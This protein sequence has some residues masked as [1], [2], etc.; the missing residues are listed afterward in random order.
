MATTIAGNCHYNLLAFYIATPNTHFC[1]VHKLYTPKYTKL[2][3]HP[4]TSF[5]IWVNLKCH[6]IHINM[7]TTD[8]EYN[9]HSNEYYCQ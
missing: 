7:Y 8:N 4:M 6:L 9:Y 3:K 1:S 2:Y 5:L